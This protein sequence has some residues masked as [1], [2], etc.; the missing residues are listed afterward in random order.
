MRS[1]ARITAGVLLIA[2]GLLLGG[3]PASTAV[4]DTGTEG[5]RVTGDR[6]AAYDKIWGSP[7]VSV[8][9][10]GDLSWGG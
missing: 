7:G 1:T 9:Y 8:D 3:L 6:E 2:G 4:P 10:H 5:T